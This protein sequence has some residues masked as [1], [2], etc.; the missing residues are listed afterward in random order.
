MRTFKE[1]YEQRLEE[2]LITLGNKRPKFGQVVI[3]AGGAGSGKGFVKDKLLGIEGKTFDVDELKKLALKSSLYKKKVKEEFGY[4]LDK[5]NLKNSKDVSKLHDIVST[6]KIPKKSQKAMF[7]SI[8]T[9]A[10]D[11]KPNLIFDVTMKDLKKLD[12]ISRNVQELGYSKDNIHIVWVINDLEIA[13]K[14]NSERDRVVDADILKD[15]HRG[16]SYTVSNI[17][18][19]GNIKKYMNGDFW[20]VFNKKYVDSILVNSK[21][22]G[23]FVE[24]AIYTK[25]KEK[26]KAIK[27][28]EKIG[29]EVIEKIKSYVPNAY[30]WA[31]VEK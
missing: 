6:L 27:S 19:D 23:E 14:Q 21:N 2:A 17:I 28:M 12:T 29:K 8:M 7:A 22:G 16:V 4:E 31:E 11:R 25:I 5:M 18:K 20:F 15:T 1:L 24:K 30:V 9:A 10:A 13:L 26:G 3:L